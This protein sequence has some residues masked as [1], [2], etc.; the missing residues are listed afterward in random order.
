MNNKNLKN[1][2]AV[3]FLLTLFLILVIS[4]LFSGNKESDGK[5][6]QQ[7]S[8]NAENV[9]GIEHEFNDLITTM[10]KLETKQKEELKIY[11]Q[12]N[13][14]NELLTQKLSRSLQAYKKMRM[15]T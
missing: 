2:I 4:Q 3:L 7:I 15:K 5:L 8:E 9:R 13:A 12:A 1:I 11:R 10:D 14:Y 6:L